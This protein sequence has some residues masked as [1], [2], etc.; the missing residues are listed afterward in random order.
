MATLILESL[1]YILLPKPIC[2]ERKHFYR[3]DKSNEPDK[4]YLCALHTSRLTHHIG[5]GGK[6]SHTTQNIDKSYHHN[7]IVLMKKISLFDTAIVMSN[8]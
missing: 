1:V 6:M 5:G 8:T 3:Q 2:G 7:N 4:V